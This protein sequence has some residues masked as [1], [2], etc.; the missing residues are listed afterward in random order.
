MINKLLRTIQRIW[1]QSGYILYLNISQNFL[2]VVT[3]VM[4]TAKIKRLLMFEMMIKEKNIN[5]S[6]EMIKNTCEDAK[7]VTVNHDR[8]DNTIAKRKRTKRQTMIYDIPHG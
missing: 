4:D 7:G 6:R 2:Q 1:L 3:V 8:T 5:E